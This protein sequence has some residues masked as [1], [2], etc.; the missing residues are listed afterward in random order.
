MAFEGSQRILAQPSCKDRLKASYNVG[1]C[2]DKVMA[3]GL[4]LSMK[5]KKEVEHFR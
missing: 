2:E 5:Q 1:R 4:F 3:S